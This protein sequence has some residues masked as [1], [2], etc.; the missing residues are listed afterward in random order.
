M[1]D[2][3]PDQSVASRLLGGQPEVAP[4]VLLDPLERLPGLLGEDAVQPVAHL[5][6]LARLDLDVAGGA[7]GAAR[8][9]V[10]QE[11]GVRE[12]VAVFARHGDVDQRRDARHPPGADHPHPRAQEAHE[13][14]NRVPRF[15]V[16]A[17]GVDEYCDLL[18]RLA[19]QGE[20]LCRH[21]RGDALGDLAAD[22]HDTRA[23]QPLGDEVVRR[24]D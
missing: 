4:G 10:Q 14:V 1:L 8:R 5:E 15:H 23:K 16:A 11:A 6:N 22:D 17:L 20:Q 21:A 12:A 9:L 19:G 13:V 18:A 2:D 7:A 24:R 3:P